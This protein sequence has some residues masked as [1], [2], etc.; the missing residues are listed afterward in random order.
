MS[1]GEYDDHDRGRYDDT[2]EPQPSNVRDRVRLRVMIPG[3]FLILLGLLSLGL[4]GLGLVNIVSNTEE[5]MKPMYDTIAQIY[6]NNP[7]GVPPFDEF[8][9]QYAPL[10]I[11]V[12]VVQV[13]GNLLILLGGISMVRL[14]GYGLALTGAVVASLGLCSI[15]CSSLPLGIWA[16]IVLINSDVKAAFRMPAVSD[17]HR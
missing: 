9:K 4:S 13:L 11:G 6:K 14:R 16:I 8:V 5:A 17:A 15:L 10:I 3:I 2:G 12:Y 7:Q 1:R